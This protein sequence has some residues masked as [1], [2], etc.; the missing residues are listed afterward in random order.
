MFL[1]LLIRAPAL[2]DWGSSLTTPF[3][4]YHLIMGPVDKHRLTGEW[5]STVDFGRTQISVPDKGHQW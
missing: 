3:N 1:L 4:L 2:S 5:A